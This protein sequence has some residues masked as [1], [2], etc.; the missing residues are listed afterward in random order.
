MGLDTV[1][2]NNLAVQNISVAL[3]TNITGSSRA[4]RG[5]EGIVGIQPARIEYSKYGEWNNPFEQAVRNGQ[6]KKPYLTATFVKANRR[7]GRGGGGR[8]TFGSTDDAAT[9]GSLTWVNTTSANYWGFSFDAVKVGSKDVTD[10]DD[11]YK[12]VIVDTGSALNYFSDT[13]AASINAQITG[14]VDSSSNS[15]TDGEDVDGDSTPYLVPCRTGLPEYENQLPR[16]KRNKPFTVTIAGR[17]FQI[18][19]SDFV[20]WPLEPQTPADRKSKKEAMCLSA[21]QPTSAAFAVLGDVFLKNHV[22][23]FDTGT[24]GPEPTFTGRRIG[25]GD[26][27]DV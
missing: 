12:R 6:L 10:Q 9:R 18:P 27:R 16:N 13:V 17:D 25:F 14:A 7:T 20:F 15:T 22:V 26:R 19:V 23:T 1:A 11:P 5:M 21:F 24:P 2:F 4:Y 8:Y 3:A